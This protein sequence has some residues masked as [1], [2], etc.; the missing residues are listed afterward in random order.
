MPSCLGLN[1]IPPWDPEAHLDLLS[2]A[3]E[4]LQLVLCKLWVRKQS[5]WNSFRSPLL[6]L[7]SISFP[8]QSLQHCILSKGYHTELS[9]PR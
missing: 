1:L 2:F 4:T 5:A 6:L 8:G 3:P 7:E 9:V